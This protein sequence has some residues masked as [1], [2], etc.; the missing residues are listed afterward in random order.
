VAGALA[1]SPLHA[2]ANTYCYTVGG[3]SACASAAITTNGSNTTLT[4]AIQNLSRSVGNTV[5]TVTAFGL[6]YIFPPTH[7]GSS[8]GFLSG[9]PGWTAGTPGIIKTSGPIL[10]AGQS[11]LWVAGAKA[12]NAATG[13]I[14]GCPPLPR[15][16]TGLS[17]CNGP[18]SFTFNLNPGVNFS[19]TGLNL[20]LQGR[21]WQPAV[22]GTGRTPAESFI[23]YS[24]NPN[25]VVTSSVP[26]PAT[27]G[28]LAI[29]L[30]GLGGIGIA[31]R[32][33]QVK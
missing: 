23:C 31:R 3:F 14:V 20:A 1:A 7:T 21:N 24:T 5:H 22:S 8:A 16:A 4:I 19:L 25:C 13:G 30:V 26:E 33:R 27:M 6:Y 9:Q 32:R 10:G 15:N 28:L 12:T 18:L 17:S 29:G 2:S 11:T